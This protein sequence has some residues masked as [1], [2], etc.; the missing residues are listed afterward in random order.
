MSS[1]PYEKQLGSSR[2]TFLKSGTIAGMASLLYEAGPAR[3]QLFAAG[4]DLLRV[5]LIG[6]G[7]RGTGAANQALRADPQA[8]LVAMGDAFHDQIAASLKTLLSE[9]EIAHQIS[10]DDD[11]K[12]SGL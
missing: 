5:G 2:R 9:P 10:V 1:M 7:G 4:D 11:H 3:S 6:C 12:F 8:R